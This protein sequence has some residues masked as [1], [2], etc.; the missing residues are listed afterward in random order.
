MSLHGRLKA[1]EQHP[2]STGDEEQVIDVVEVGSDGSE[3]L[4]ERIYWRHGSGVMR[5]ETYEDGKM[6]KREE[7]N[8][9]EPNRW[10]EGEE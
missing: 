6:V 1:L 7:C 4:L 5:T 9:N 8:P 3:A 2:A 10:D